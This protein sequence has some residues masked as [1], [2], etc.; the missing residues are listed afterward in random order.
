M[1]LI[2]LIV[3][4]ILLDFIFSSHFPSFMVAFCFNAFRLLL[5]NSTISKVG[6]ILFLVRA[7]EIEYIYI[8]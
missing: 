8:N 4:L 7:I 1:I 3:P 6:N 5:A 2:N